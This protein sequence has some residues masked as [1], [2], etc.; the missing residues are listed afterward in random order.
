V[1]CSVLL[2]LLAAPPGAWSSGCA[3]QPYSWSDD[4]LSCR[5]APAGLV[6]LEGWRAGLSGR[7]DGS[8]ETPGLSLGVA[9][10]RAGRVVLGAGAGWSEAGGA[11]TLDLGL[12]AAATLRG[13]PIGFMEGVFGPSI[14]VG[15]SLAWTRTGEGE[16]CLSASIGLQF[17]IFPTIAVG[18]DCSGLRL[19]GDR[20]VERILGYGVTCVYD[21]SFRAHL[22]VR[23]GRPAVGGELAVTDRLTVRT[24]SDG[25]LWVAGLAVPVG[26]LEFAYS[27]SLSGSGAVH[28]AGLE[29]SPGG[30]R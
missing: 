20:L 16:G 3:V 21:R 1:I 7:L 22:S 10:F 24:G 28:R 19:A 14:S 12:A 9:G 11:D 18:A 6:R 17:S 15:S 25:S 13:D 5:I 23:D 4:A 2:A 8:G 30:S 27:V 29:F 26:D